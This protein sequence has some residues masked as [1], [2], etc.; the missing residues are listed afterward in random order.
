MTRTSPRL[1]NRMARS[2]MPDRQLYAYLLVFELPFGTTSEIA[3]FLNAN[4][5]IFLNWLTV[6][7]NSFF[8]ISHLSATELGKAFR[9]YTENQGRFI[10]LDVKTDR[11]GWLPKKAWDFINNPQSV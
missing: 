6:L 11:S 5:N 3:D 2:S 8:I 10:I 7:P 9:E 4:G 1:S